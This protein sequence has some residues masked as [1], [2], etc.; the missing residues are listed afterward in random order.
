MKNILAVL[1]ILFVAC[2]L[3]HAQTGVGGSWRVEGIGPGFPWTAVLKT[4]ASNL[5][6]TVTGCGAPIVAISE[7]TVKGNIVTFKC[8][9]PDGRV[10]TFTGT[11]CQ[12]SETKAS[13]VARTAGWPA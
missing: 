5:E 1:A 11:V 10:I 8:K 7:G 6:G 12:P 3:T 2:A 9:S 4:D 13:V